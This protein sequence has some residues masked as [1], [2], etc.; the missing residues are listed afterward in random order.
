MHQLFSDVP[1]ITLDTPYG[2]LELKYDQDSGLKVKITFDPADLT[3]LAIG[4]TEAIETMF[5]AL[6]SLLDLFVPREVPSDPQ[7]LKTRQNAMDRKS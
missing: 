4:L 3:N 6:F 2:N 5:D 1:P 7:S